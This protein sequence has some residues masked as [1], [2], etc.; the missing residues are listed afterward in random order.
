MHSVTAIAHIYHRV[1]R[2]FNHGIAGGTT[3]WCTN[4]LHSSSKLHVLLI[5][6][7]LIA[8][9]KAGSSTVCLDNR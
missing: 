9:R 6:C 8:V 3:F 7:A 2:G 4:W 5:A 1:V